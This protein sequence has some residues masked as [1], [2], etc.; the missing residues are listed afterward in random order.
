M[1]NSKKANKRRSRG[2]QLKFCMIVIVIAYFAKY[3]FRKL[4]FACL[5]IYS[6]DRVLTENQTNMFFAFLLISAL[7][8][9][10]LVI[11][12]KKTW[13]RAFMI[14][15]LPSGFFIILRFA[16]IF[17]VYNIMAILLSVILNVINIVENR[18]DL[19]HAMRTRDNHFLRMIRRDCVDTHLEVA[20]TYLSWAAGIYLFAIFASYI[21]SPVSNTGLFGSAVYSTNKNGVEVVDIDSLWDINRDILVKLNDRY[22]YEIDFQEKVDALQTLVDIEM[23]Y[24]GCGPVQLVAEDMEKEILAGYYSSS[25]GYIA[26]NADIVE[27]DVELAI[28]VL[29]HESYHVYQ[30]ECVEAFYSMELPADYSDLKMFRDVATWNY[31]GTHYYSGRDAESLE[32]YYLYAE[33]QLEISADEYS[34]QRI[35]YW[36]EYINSIEMGGI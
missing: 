1:R 24:L 11:K 33:Q 28:S 31:E 14:G 18:S 35:G 2:M 4:G 27:Q 5:Y 6:A 3:L 30:I 17:K 25:G 16:Y 23:I 9:Y 21:N 22:Y 26:I 29:L 36:I 15:I 20:F 12:G 32:D 13:L 8:I 10:L 7:G 19:L 34:N